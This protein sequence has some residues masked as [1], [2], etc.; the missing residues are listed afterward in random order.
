[1]RSWE[2]RIYI[3]SKIGITFDDEGNQIIKYSEPKMYEFNVQPISSEI[4]LMEF[5]EKASMIQKAV[6]PTNIILKKMMLHTWMIYLLWE[7]VI[8]VIM[9]IIDFIHQEIKIR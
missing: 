9:L 8:L 6:I 7:K 3:A 1:M 4:D 5:G 2:K